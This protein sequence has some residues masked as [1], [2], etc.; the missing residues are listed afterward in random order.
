M[1]R[2]PLNINDLAG[3]FAQCHTVLWSG[4]PVGSLSTP[5]SRARAPGADQAIRPTNIQLFLEMHVALGGF[6]CRLNKEAA[7]R[8]VHRG[9][10]LNGTARF[11]L[12]RD[13]LMTSAAGS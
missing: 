13:W 5:E 4:P 10:E 1:A 11:R 7:P 6:T 9:E 2:N 12:R 3:G 8:P